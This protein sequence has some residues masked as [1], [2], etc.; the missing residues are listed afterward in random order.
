[1][2]FLIKDNNLVYNRV[3]AVAMKYKSKNPFLTSS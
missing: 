1:M 3:V 2:N